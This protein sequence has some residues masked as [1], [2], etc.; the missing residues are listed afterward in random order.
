M[1]SALLERF[2]Q[3]I[4]RHTGLIIPE[5]DYLL[6][7]KQIRL[8]T[9]RFGFSGPELY[10]SLLETPTHES[11]ME[12]RELVLELTIG[13]SYFFRDAGQM[14]LLKR[15]LLP[16]LLAKRSPNKPLRIWSAGCSTGEEPYTLA[17]MLESL[18]LTLDKSGVFILGSD[19][20][21]TALKTAR[22]GIYGPWSFRGM[23]KDLLDVYF[24]RVKEEWQLVERIRKRVKFSRI[25]LIRDGF[26]GIVGDLREMDLIVCRNVF[27]YFD[28]ETVARLMTKFAQTLRPGGYLMTGH[29]ELSPEVRQAATRGESGLVL[30]T[31]PESVVFQRPLESL[32]A[33]FPSFP[34]SEVPLAS[35]PPF[36]SEKAGFKGGVGSWSKKPVSTSKK[37]TAQPW[38]GGR[39]TSAKPTPKG[40]AKSPDVEGLFAE[41]SDLFGR[42]AYAESAARAKRGLKQSS[43]HFGLLHLLARCHANLGDRRAAEGCCRQAMQVD[44]F[45]AA[46]LYLLAHI[47]EEQGQDGEA[48]ELLNKVIYLDPTHIPAFLELGAIYQRRGDLP[49]AQKMR[50]SALE[51]L[52]SL[53]DDASIETYEE[54]TAGALVAQVEG[55]LGEKN[56]E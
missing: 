33:D 30:K 54:W 39:S 18:S 12:W 15:T 42:G 41:A 32:A 25:N 43:N 14:A 22:Q 48:R 11:E 35:P 28:Q 7:A 24:Q 52:R 56:R 47:L 4:A 51:L 10:L 45:N 27:I 50:Q 17:M 6:L 31:F 29:A 21:G 3:L 34:S 5:P 2:S 1:D 9:R 44:G 38:K 13:E 46:P 53:P 19:I 49:R 55:M 26:P 8:R 37:T 20:N 36:K 16:E 40:I 23:D